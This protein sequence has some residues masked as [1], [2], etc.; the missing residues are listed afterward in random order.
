[1]GSFGTHDGGLNIILADQIKDNSVKFRVTICVSLRIEKVKLGD[2][3]SKVRGG[4][5]F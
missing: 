4:F 3:W 2:E 1:M 5:S